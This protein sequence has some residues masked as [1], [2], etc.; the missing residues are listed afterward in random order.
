MT[1]IT[2]AWES[3]TAALKLSLNVFQTTAL[4]EELL[5]YFYERVPYYIESKKHWERGKKE[6]RKKQL[7][8]KEILNGR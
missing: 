8:K 1:T 6:W 7:Q 5:S 2:Q 3:W 4:K